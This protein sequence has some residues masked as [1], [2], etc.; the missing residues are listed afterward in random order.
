MPSIPSF[1]RYQ[2]QFQVY[3]IAMHKLQISKFISVYLLCSNIIP[4]FK[5]EVI[6]TQQDLFRC[7]KEF[8]LCRQVCPSII[9]SSN[10]ISSFFNWQIYKQSIL[11][12]V[13]WFSVVNNSM[14]WRSHSYSGVAYPWILKTIII[15]SLVLSFAY[16]WIWILPTSDWL[17]LYLW[18][19]RQ[20]RC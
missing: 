16:P 3:K 7:I 1:L 6:F 20:N 18:W 13:V 10:H 19:N 12:Y 2:K 8:K 15:V 4:E 9:L 14:Q 5:R 17:N 11:N